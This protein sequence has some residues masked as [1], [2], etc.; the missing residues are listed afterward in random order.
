MFCNPATPA[1]V[2]GMRFSRLKFI[3]PRCRVHFSKFCLRA[4]AG[5]NHAVVE[6]PPTSDPAP[7]PAARRKL[8]LQKITW[9][10][11]ASMLLGW[12]YGWASPRAFP[13][14]ASFGFGYGMMHG[15]LMPMAL[16]SLILG[17]NV[18]IFAPENTGCNYKIGFILGINACGLVFFGPLVWRPRVDSK[19]QKN[20]ER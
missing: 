11:I 4:T 7:I 2:S 3:L 8:W 1:C 13:K 9:F 20:Q 19:N 18:E 5:E 12:F 16:P 6:M 14:D 17:Q 10:L 15:A